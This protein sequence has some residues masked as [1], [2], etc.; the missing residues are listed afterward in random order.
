MDF[1][2]NKPIY[3]QIVDFCFQ[4]I[5]TEEWPENDRIPSVR[6]LAMTLQVNPNT[7]MRAFEYMQSEEIIYSKRGMGYYVAEN[8]RGQISKLQKKEFFEEVLPETFRSMNLLDISID[9]IVKQ[10]EQFKKEVK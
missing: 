10:Y 1:K 2:A 4:H 5:L 7:A 9:D 8:A 3:L 6:E